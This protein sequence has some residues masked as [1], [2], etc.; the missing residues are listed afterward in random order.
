MA[1]L[2][3]SPGR[4][5][6]RTAAVG[7]LGLVIAA[8]LPV[9][10]ASAAPGTACANRTNN[11]YS[12]LLECVTLQGV[13]EHQ[14]QLQKIADNNDGPDYP[15]TR[16]AGTEGYAAS[17]DYVAGLLRDA[18][19]RVTLDEFQFEFVFPALLQQLTPVDAAYETGAFTGSPPG[20]VTG[21]VIPVDINLTGDRASTSGCE[22]ADFAGLDFSGPDDIA[23]IQRG[24]CTFAEK[25]VNAEAAGAEA[26]IIFNQGNDPTREALIVGTLVPSPGR[27]HHPGRGGQ[28]RRRRRA[29]PARLDRAR[30]GRTQRDPHRRQ[31]HRRA[32]RPEHR[33]R[34]DGRSA[35]GHR[36]RRSRGSTTTAPV[37]RRCS[38]QRCRCRR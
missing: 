20:D 35:P 32:P 16:A 10:T 25:A 15:G 38:R 23:L 26:V 36:H 21:N 37:P 28:L 34:R 33:Q 22:A 4:A 11:T 19:Y 1:K 17:V 30:A 12:K 8:L 3:R 27:D 6:A 18:G 14:A 24:T 29:G 9:Q 13:R 5:S 7:V 31:R 2:F